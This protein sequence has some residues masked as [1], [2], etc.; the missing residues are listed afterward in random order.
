MKSR[1]VRRFHLRLMMFMPFG[2]GVCAFIAQVSADGGEHGSDGRPP[3][4]RCG[5]NLNVA[6][7]SWRLNA[8]WK[9]ALHRKLGQHSSRGSATPV[10]ACDA[11]S[12]DAVACRAGSDNF[13]GGKRGGN[14]KLLPTAYCLLPTAYCFLLAACCS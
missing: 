2:H 4:P 12:V 7:P 3:V 8:G 6:P 10:G 14:L 11:V 9:P 5:P 1:V 13:M